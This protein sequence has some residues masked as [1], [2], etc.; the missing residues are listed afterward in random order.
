MDPRRF[1]LL[2]PLGVR[3]ASF[4]VRLTRRALPLEHFLAAIAQPR[5]AAV[6]TLAGAAVKVLDSIHEDGAKLIEMRAEDVIKLRTAQTR[7]GSSSCSSI[8]PPASGP[9]S[10]RTSP[11]SRR[12]R[13]RYARSICASRT[14]CAGSTATRRSLPAA[15]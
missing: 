8:R 14:C 4:G 10:A 7:A 13:S 1:M 11:S 15:G 6:R 9:H 12:S 5:Q 3:L 2:P